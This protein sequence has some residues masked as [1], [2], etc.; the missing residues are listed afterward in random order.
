VDEAHQP[1]LARPV[2]AEV[3]GVRSRVREGAV[4]D[5]V[6]VDEPDGIVGCDGD[7]LRL[8]AAP[9]VVHLERGGSRVDR[10]PGGRLEIDHG[11]S[12]LVGGEALVRRE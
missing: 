11:A 10:S 7:E 9:A 5:R 2:D 1:A 3:E 4:E 6:V 8:E 12:Q